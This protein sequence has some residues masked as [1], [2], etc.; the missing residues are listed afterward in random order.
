MVC[1]VHCTNVHHI[2]FILLFSE[3]HLFIVYIRLLNTSIKYIGRISTDKKESNIF[4]INEGNSDGICCK[5]RF[6]KN[7]RKTRR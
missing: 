4:L 7:T 5:V 6:R 3:L 2:P 1:I